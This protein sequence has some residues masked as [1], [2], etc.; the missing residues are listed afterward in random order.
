MEPYLDPAEM[1]EYEIQA[2]IPYTGY[3]FSIQSGLIGYVIWLCPQVKNRPLLAMSWLGKYVHEAHLENR[4]DGGIILM[5]FDDNIS[6]ALKGWMGM[7]KI[8][9]QP[10]PFPYLHM[11]HWFLLLWC[12]TFPL[13]LVDDYG[14]FT[15]AV[16]P[17]PAVMLFALEEVSEEIEATVHRV[18]SSVLSEPPMCIGPVW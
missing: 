5:G 15:L 11:L 1:H 18:S 12:L 8:C 10:L 7:N 2:S 9:F 16:G 17:I 14:W 4:L 6:S 13:T 3:L